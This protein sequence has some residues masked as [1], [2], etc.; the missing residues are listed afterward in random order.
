M[1]LLR[2]TSTKSELYNCNMSKNYLHLYLNYRITNN[3]A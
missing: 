3:S 1:T 2:E